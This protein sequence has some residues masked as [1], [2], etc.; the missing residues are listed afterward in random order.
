MSFEMDYE[1][2]DG[3]G[4]DVELHTELHRLADEL[5]E[6]QDVLYGLRDRAVQEDTRE[7]RDR[8]VTAII[9]ARDAQAEAKRLARL[10]G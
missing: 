2:A 7:L 4:P 5:G 1:H 3:F 10:Q 9:A 6:V 8:I